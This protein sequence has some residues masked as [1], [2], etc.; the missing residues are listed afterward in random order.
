MKVENIAQKRREIESLLS[1][2]VGRNV[3]V[4]FTKLGRD[5]PYSVAIQTT[6]YEFEETPSGP[7]GPMYLSINASMLQDESQLDDLVQAIGRRYKGE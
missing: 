6:L 2:T 7:R 1:D 5:T 3:E 4:S